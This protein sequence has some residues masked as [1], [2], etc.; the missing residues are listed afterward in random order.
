MY[1]DGEPMSWKHYIGTARKV[2]R[3]QPEAL[4]HGMQGTPH[5]DLGLGVSPRDSGHQRRTLRGRQFVSI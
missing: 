2:S 1:E 4:A 3:A 5:D